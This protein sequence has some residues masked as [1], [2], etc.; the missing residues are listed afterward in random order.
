MVYQ[1][2]A[3]R[4]NQMERVIIMSRYTT[5]INDI[6]N[7]YLPEEIRYTDF[8]LNTLVEKTHNQFFNFEYDFYSPEKADKDKF[9]QDFLLT[10]L[11]EYIGY[12]TLGMFR[13]RLLSHLNTNMYWYKKMYDAII[14]GDNPFENQNEKT[15][16]VH[17]DE[18]TDKRNLTN[19]NTGTE[20]TKTSN[21][22][23]LSDKTT[24][25]NTNNYQNI[26][27]DN[28]QVTIKTHDY[29][30]EMDRATTKD[31]SSTT[32]TRQ[33]TNKGD[34]LLE[35]NLTN[36]DEE[37]KHHLQNENESVEHTGLTGESRAD[38]IEKYANQIFNLEKM[39]IDSCSGM[40]LKLW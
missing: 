39:L 6:I 12:E 34:G 1:M 31:S 29:A 26:H 8:S 23:N 18:Q 32:D 11:N 20:H 19:R 24:T 15:I 35:R 37:G 16:S 7:H 27:S 9:E 22:E 30:S 10:Y 40:F 36:T 14:S 4:T 5:T 28:P 17:N 33:T 21:T 2:Q 38:V 13:A 3:E 25:T